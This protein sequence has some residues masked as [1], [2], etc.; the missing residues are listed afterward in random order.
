MSAEKKD[1]TATELQVLDLR[2]SFVSETFDR[3]EVLRGVDLEVS[4]GEAVAIT[5]A[6]GSGKST[7]LH[8]LGGVVE[9]DHGSIL[10]GNTEVEKLSGNAASHFRQFQVGFVFQFHYLMTDLSTIEN[11]ALP[12]LIERRRR[13]QAFA[14]AKALLTELGLG[15]TLNKPVAQLSGGEQQRAALA[16]ALISSPALLLADEPTGNLDDAMGDSIGKTLI[17][18]IRRRGSIGVIATHNKKLAALC[19]RVLLLEA[20]R[21]HEV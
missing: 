6:S 11:V 17:N 5:G 3:I 15:T 14:E 4:P 12:L 16:R 7:L 8:L 9:S 20:G 2:K 19:D 21:L 18:H 1:K 10:L 13:S